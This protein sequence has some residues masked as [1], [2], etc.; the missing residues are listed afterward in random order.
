MVNSGCWLR[1]L[2]P[3]GSHL[4][5][6]PVFAPKFV[7]TYVKVFVQGLNLRVELWECPKATT[8]RPTRTERLAAWG[9]MPDQ[10][11][12]NAEPRVISASEILASS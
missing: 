1:Q 3:V 6:P 4:R 11:D 8:N 2:Q 9:K 12:T 10:P 5:W 7:L